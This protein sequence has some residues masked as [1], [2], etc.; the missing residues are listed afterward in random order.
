V[1]KKKKKKS[2]VNST[3]NRD[4]RECFKDRDGP[5]IWYSV[6]SFGLGRRTLYG[7]TNGQTS[8]R[9]PQTNVIFVRQTDGQTSSR[10][11]PADRLYYRRPMRTIRTTASCTDRAFSQPTVEVDNRSDETKRVVSTIPRSTRER[12][13]FNTAC[14]YSLR[15]PQRQDRIFSLLFFS[16]SFSVPNLLSKP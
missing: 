16:L 7:Q 2:L 14:E 5:S 10:S 4:G 1:K 8:N 15:H 6:L 12:A 11:P 3:G 9:S 13:L